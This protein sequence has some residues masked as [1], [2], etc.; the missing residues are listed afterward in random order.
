M[1]D[2]VAVRELLS[3]FDLSLSPETIDKLL[4]YL[5]L[6]IR[7]NRKIN[8]TAIETPE[9]C[10]TRHFG[11]S[12]LISKVVKLTG[13]LLDIGSGAGFPGLA[14]KLIAPD[15]DAALLEPT[16]KKRAFLKEVTRVCG[17]TRVEVVGNRLEEFAR[18][19]EPQT[20]A[21]ITIRAVGGLEPLIRNAAGLLKSGGHFCLWLGRQQ[22]REIRDATPDFH[23]YEPF[24]IPIS[25]DRCILTGSRG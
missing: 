12:F 19:Q 10:V 15:L 18:A 8:L 11:E 1:L 4:I 20:F 23:W 6:L 9:E 13:S 2:P 22:V 21:L 25:R 24:A 17:L 14:I 5:D 7:W 3:P 16:A